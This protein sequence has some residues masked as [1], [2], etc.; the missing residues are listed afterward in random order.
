MP[1]RRP[2]RLTALIK[3]RPRKHR[4]KQQTGSGSLVRQSA[5][6]PQAIQQTL[7]PQLL[8]VTR[9]LSFICHNESAKPWRNAL[10]LFCSA[11]AS[12]H[13]TSHASLRDDA[14]G[15][16]SARQLQLPS[17]Q[18][19][20]GVHATTQLHAVASSLLG[21]H[22]LLSSALASACV[23]SNA[24]LA[25]CFIRSAFFLLS[26][27]R[28]NVR[29]QAIDLAS[30]QCAA[31]RSGYAMRL[32]SARLHWASPVLLKACARSTA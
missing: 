24:S 22:C 1:Q 13:I 3:Q 17:E 5:S 8:V 30:H 32:A 12:T 4:R 23:S 18:P 2:Q 31:C 16:D 20:A 7:S 10:L 28:R 29:C 15:P 21:H 26:T 27:C 6:H 14:T 25:Y 19:G 9:L 11:L